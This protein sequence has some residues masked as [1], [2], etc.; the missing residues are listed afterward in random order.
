FFKR[1]HVLSG[2]KLHGGAALNSETF[3]DQQRANAAHCKLHFQANLS[4]KLST[5]TIFFH[6]LVVCSAFKQC[7]PN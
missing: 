7:H 2:A 5:F 1:S 6:M 3:R 4:L